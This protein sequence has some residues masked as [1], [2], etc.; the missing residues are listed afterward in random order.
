[1]LLRSVPGKIFTIV[2]EHSTFSAFKT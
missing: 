2:A 1:M